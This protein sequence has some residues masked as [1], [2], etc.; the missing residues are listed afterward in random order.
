[1]SDALTEVVPFSPTDRF[2]PRKSCEASTGVVKRSSIM[3]RRLL[4]EERS[5]SP[6]AGVCTLNE[7]EW[8]WPSIPMPAIGSERLKL[9]R[10][11]LEVA[12]HRELDLAEVALEPDVRAGETGARARGH[13]VH[14]GERRHLG[15]ECRS[16][17]GAVA[18][19][20]VGELG[21]PGTVDLR[22]SQGPRVSLRRGDVAQDVARN[23]RRARSRNRSGRRPLPRS[24]AVRRT[25]R[26]S[27]ASRCSS[28][29]AGCR[30]TL[31]AMSL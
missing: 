2:Q 16:H 5:K 31:C 25:A 30:P 12:L 22:G 26:T 3:V 8:V 14:A 10:D 13:V 7:T 20:Q 24:A 11:G 21:G 27:A 15:E 28:W 23:L 17:P 18:E 19:D 29:I 1:M 4:L 9:G 6:C